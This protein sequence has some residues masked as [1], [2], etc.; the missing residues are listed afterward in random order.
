MVKGIRKMQVAGH[1]SVQGS[2]T[3]RVMG[4]AM[5]CK[6]TQQMMRLRRHLLGT[7]QLAINEYRFEYFLSLE[8]CCGG[9][10]RQYC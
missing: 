2:G 9:Q 8:D 10:G 3:G 4:M 6:K 1:K 7:C 5:V